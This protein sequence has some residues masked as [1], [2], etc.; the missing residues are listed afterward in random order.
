MILQVECFPYCYSHFSVF[1]LTI[2][3]LWC[4]CFSQLSRWGRKMAALVTGFYIPLMG[5]KEDFLL[6][7]PKKTCSP[8]FMALTKRMELCKAQR[9]NIYGG[10]TW[11]EDVLIIL[12]YVPVFVIFENSKALCSGSIFLTLVAL[13][14]NSNYLITFRLECPSMCSRAHGGFHFLS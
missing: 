2:C 7:F 6:S 1:S 12:F 4:V 10:D 3:S 5:N 11:S 8:R 9:I 14:T 13:T